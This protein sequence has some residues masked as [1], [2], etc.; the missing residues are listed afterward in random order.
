MQKKD[1]HAE[2][3]ENLAHQMVE[4]K[5]TCKEQNDLPPPPFT[6]LVVHPSGKSFR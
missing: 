4:K 3:K 1:I 5:I 2:Q 6:F